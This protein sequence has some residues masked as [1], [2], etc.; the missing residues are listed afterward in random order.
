MDTRAQDKDIDQGKA[1]ALRKIERG[2]PKKLDVAHS[3]ISKG[4]HSDTTGA[5]FVTVADQVTFHV[6]LNF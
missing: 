1:A 5:V 2:K 4:T 6:T 3:G